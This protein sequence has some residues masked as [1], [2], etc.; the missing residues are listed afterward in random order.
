VIASSENFLNVSRTSP[1][2]HKQPATAQLVIWLLLSGK[3]WSC[4]AL[5][6]TCT[7][8]IYAPQHGTARHGMAW[9]HGKVSL[10]GDGAGRCSTS[11]CLEAT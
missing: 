1:Q 6:V 9:A 10:S 11:N 5:K 8:S 2:I 7:S 3:G 4:R